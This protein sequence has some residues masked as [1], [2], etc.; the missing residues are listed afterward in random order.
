VRREQ[1]ALGLFF[2]TLAVVTLVWTAWW[3]DV[4]RERREDGDVVVWRGVLADVTDVVVEEPDAPPWRL[5]REAEGWTVQLGQDT[6]PADPSVAVDVVD[7]LVEAGR[8]VA[9]DGDDLAMFGLDTPVVVRWTAL[10]TSYALEMGRTAPVGGRTY[11]RTDETGVVAVYGGMGETLRLA[12]SQVVDSALSRADVIAGVVLMH[13]GEP[14]W[15][16]AFADGAW[17]DGTRPAEQVSDL[18]Y[19]WKDLRVAQ[20]TT[21]LDATLPWMVRFIAA[22]GGQEVRRLGKQGDR[23]GVD[24]GDG[25]L[26]WLPE[27]AT[28]WIDTLTEGS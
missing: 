22:D 17:G 8:G 24:L 19:A 20:W 4:P 7:A 12:R 13:G 16:A 15:E 3:R 27:S 11:V 10:E 9:I 5:I 1:Q 18:V 25:R 28:R 21:A 14:V 26:G 2:G 23:W 6:W